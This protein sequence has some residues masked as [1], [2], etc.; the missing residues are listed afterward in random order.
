MSCQLT[1][2]GASIV[3]C[4]AEEDSD[5]QLSMWAPVKPHTAALL[6]MSDEL[7]PTN[8][9]C[10]L[11]REAYDDSGLTDGWWEYRSNGSGWWKGAS[12]MMQSMVFGV[13]LYETCLLPEPNTDALA[14]T[15]LGSMAALAHARRRAGRAEKGGQE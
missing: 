7:D 9:L 2:D 12:Q 5:G 10:E 1:G 14:L 13:G 11:T 15:A 4:R 3:S 6:L 8:G